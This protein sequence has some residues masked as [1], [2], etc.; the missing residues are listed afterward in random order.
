VQ[1]EEVGAGHHIGYRP[2]VGVNQHLNSLWADCGCAWM[3]W[4]R[5]SLSDFD[6]AF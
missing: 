1:R 3:L 5:F 4:D 6:S 2:G